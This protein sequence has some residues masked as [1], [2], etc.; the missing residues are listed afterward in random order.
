[1]GTNNGFKAC[2]FGDCNIKIDNE[3]YLQLDSL[4]DSGPYTF[5]L[6][7]EKNNKVGF[8]QWTQAENPLKA[9]DKASVV[10]NYEKFVK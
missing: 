6:E 9:T 7:W 1:M 5:K 10:K 4:S 8:M 2:K 3:N